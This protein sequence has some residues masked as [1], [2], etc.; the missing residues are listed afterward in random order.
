MHRAAGL[1]A[2]AARSASA[3]CTNSSLDVC[4]SSAASGCINGST[5][6]P[7]SRS[8][9]AG[10]AEPAPQD[11]IEVFVNGESTQ[12]VKGSTVLHA[13]EAAGIDIPRCC[14]GRNVSLCSH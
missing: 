8:Y 1:A 4:S 5:A 11:T 3:R 7:S 9:A 2:R 6:Q 12:V 13:C 10:A 14:P